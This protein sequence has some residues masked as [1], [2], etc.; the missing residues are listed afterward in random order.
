MV[1][2]TSPING[3]EQRSRGSVGVST[4]GSGC[5]RRRQPETA[6]R[7]EH[8]AGRRQRQ[9]SGKPPTQVAV[10]LFKQGPR[11]LDE[12]RRYPSAASATILIGARRQDI[13]RDQQTGVSG[14]ARDSPRTLRGARAP[15]ADATA[16]MR[17]ELRPQSSCEAGHPL[18]PRSIACRKR[19]DL[20]DDASTGA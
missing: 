14:T 2:A 19:R 11:D 7:C 3:V 9:R 4:S 15:D 1:L 13:H 18:D 17:I 20:Q 6:S 10:A 16:R 8:R 5:G 12:H